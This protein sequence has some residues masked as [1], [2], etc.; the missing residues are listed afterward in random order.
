LAGT[1]PGDSEL[2]QL[3]HALMKERALRLK[4][5]YLVTDDRNGMVHV[6]LSLPLALSAGSARIRSR[7]S[8]R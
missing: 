5:K 6:R 8:K 7:S 2:S 1:A 3:D 4:G